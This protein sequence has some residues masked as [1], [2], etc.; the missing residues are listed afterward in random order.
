MA[1][2][3]GHCPTCNAHRNAQV[4]A[5]HEQVEGS[6]E[7][8]FDPDLQGEAYRILKCAGCDTVYFQHESLHVRPEDWDDP[9]DAFVPPFDHLKDHLDYLREHDLITY[10]NES[11]WPLPKRER[12]DWQ[13]FPDVA[14][15]KLLD[16]VY[17]A[18]EQDLR[19]LAAIGMRTV[20]D[21]ASEYLGV[22]PY[23]SFDKK[24]DQLLHEG[25]IGASEKERLDVLTDA[26]SAAA[27]RAW[28][29]DLQQLNTLAKIM[30]HFLQSILLKAEAGTLKLAIPPRQKKRNQGGRGLP[31][32]VIEFPSPRPP[33]SG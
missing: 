13:K 7:G 18:L 25:H 4:L 22:E 1:M 15:T 16:S 30:E 2:I 8:S 9:N 3:K 19:V 21:Q 31:T 24:L 20:F 10:E 33:K 26:G 12:P 28:E 5:E 11:Y 23:K 29:P 27:H 14:L 17:T 6:A 32:D